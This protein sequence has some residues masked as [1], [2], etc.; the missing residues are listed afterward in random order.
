M[1][2]YYIILVFILLGLSLAIMS[3]ITYRN[4]ALQA[5]V[6]LLTGLAESILNAFIQSALLWIGFLLAIWMSGYAVNLKVEVLCA[7]LFVIVAL[8]LWLNRKS[9]ATTQSYD[10]CQVR[11]SAILSVALGID[12]FLLGLGL[13][14]LPISFRTFV[15]CV[16][17]PFLLILVFTLWGIMLGRKDV[18]IS[19]KRWRLFAILMLL[20]SAMIVA[21]A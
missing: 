21:L 1:Q 3:M 17:I 18:A 6:G 11:V 5:K 10:I 14:V 16:L 12:A 19:P 20:V 15:W 8:K 4:S 7:A 13:G 2:I 9:S